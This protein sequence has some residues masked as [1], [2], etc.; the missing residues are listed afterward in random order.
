M[1]PRRRVGQRHGKPY[2]F[3]VDTIAMRVDG[4]KFYQADNGVWLT[5]QVSA[6]FLTPVS[7]PEKF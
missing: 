5:D 6:R 4:F 7:E 3:R 1:K 2:I